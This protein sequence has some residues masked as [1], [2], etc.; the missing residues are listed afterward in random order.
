MLWRTIYA[1]N[2]LSQLAHTILLLM[3]TYSQRYEAKI[4]LIKRMLII[5]ANYEKCIFIYGNVLAIVKRENA[6]ML[7]TYILCMMRQSV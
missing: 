1:L 5:K 3:S 2:I 7:C 6:L 4:N